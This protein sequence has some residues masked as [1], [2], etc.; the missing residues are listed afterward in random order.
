M[1]WQ[2]RTPT[3][4]SYTGKTSASVTKPT[5]VGA[6]EVLIILFRPPQ[7]A[8]NFNPPGTLTVI[9]VSTDYFKAF[10]RLTD[11]SEGASFSF[12]WQTSGNGIWACIAA[13][14]DS[15]EQPIFDVSGA[16][17][18]SAGDT[19]HTAPSQTA[20]YPNSLLVALFGGSAGTS[21][22]WTPGGSLTER[23]DFQHSSNQGAT[24]LIATEVQ[25]SPGSTGTKTATS[26]ASL[27][28]P[29]RSLAVFAAPPVG[30]PYDKRLGGIP[31]MGGRRQAFGGVHRWVQRGALHVPAYLAE[32]A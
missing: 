1:T 28:G 12:S 6:G 30:Q 15:G 4:G 2:F 19:S 17:S 13:Y 16:N 3:T 14:E 24:L 5:G 20:T 11:G 10:Y 31:F 26:T 29:R 7:H 25:A 32:A 21:C 23:V 8:V 18:G 27:T 22:T 9:D